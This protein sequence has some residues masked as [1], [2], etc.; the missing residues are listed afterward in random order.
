[1]CGEIVLRPERHVNRLLCL[2]ERH[3]ESKFSR[4][5]A[6]KGVAAGTVLVASVVSVATISALLVAFGA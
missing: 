1:M 2:F 6:A 3:G 4:Y 5:D